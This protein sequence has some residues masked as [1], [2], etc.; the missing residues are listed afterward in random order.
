MQLGDITIRGQ[1]VAT[2]A[3][4]IS[5]LDEAGEYGTEDPLEALRAHGD[6]EK[7]SKG[8]GLAAASRD[9]RV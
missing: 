4:E 1:P 9:G 6:D 5:A 8:V 2:C 7:V 3:V